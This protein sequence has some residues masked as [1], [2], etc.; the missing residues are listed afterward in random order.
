M[1]TRNQTTFIRVFRAV[2]SICDTFRAST[3][4]YRVEFGD[5]GREQHDLTLTWSVVK[6]ASL[7]LMSKAKKTRL[8]DF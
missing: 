1:E 6:R 8:G 2:E 5:F 7:K 3:H 4:R